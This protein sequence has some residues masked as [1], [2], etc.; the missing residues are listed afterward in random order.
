[1]GGRVGKVSHYRD[2]FIGGEPLGSRNYGLAEIRGGQEEGRAGGLFQG[3]GDPIPGPD[4]AES[5]RVWGLGRGSAGISL[6]V[7]FLSI[8]IIIT[9][10]SRRPLDSK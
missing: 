6:G 9:H 7:A 5:R 4:W 1:M 10:V 8:N 3:S 2:T